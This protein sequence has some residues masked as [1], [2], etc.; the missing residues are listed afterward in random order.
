MATQQP[1]KTLAERMEIV[2]TAVAEAST[3]LEADEYK[4]FL[5]EL[6][7]DA[8]GWRMDLEGLGS[9]ELPEGEG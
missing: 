4:D 5:E 3:G 1:K 8:E 9:D 7:A 6:L 2:R